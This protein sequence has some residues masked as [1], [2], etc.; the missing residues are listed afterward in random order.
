MSVLEKDPVEEQRT[1]DRAKREEEERQAAQEQIYQVSFLARLFILNGGL[2]Q[3]K[4]WCSHFLV[5]TITCQ[6]FHVSCLNLFCLL[7]ITSSWTSSIMA[8]KKIA[9]VWRLIKF[10]QC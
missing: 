8:E 3:L 7:L 2:L 10:L 6:V 9:D 1:A 4:C 5:E